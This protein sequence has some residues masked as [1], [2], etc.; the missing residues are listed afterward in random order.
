MKKLFLL[1]LL[2]FIQVYSQQ[3]SDVIVY[4]QNN[5]GFQHGFQDFAVDDNGQI[6]QVGTYSDALNPGGVTVFDG[7]HWKFTKQGENNFAFKTAYRVFYSSNSG[8]YYVYGGILRSDVAGQAYFIQKFNS[9]TNSWEIIGDSNSFNYF[10]G[11]IDFYVNETGETYATGSGG[12]W[13]LSPG[14][15]EKIFPENNPWFS[16]DYILPKPDG[17]MYLID[18]WTDGWGGS[19]IALWNYNG[20]ELDTIDTS[21]DSA[22]STKNVTLDEY[23]N[24]WMLDSYAVNT[25]VK[26]SGSSIR[27]YS[28]PAESNVSAR[29]MARDGDNLWFGM[30]T[31]GNILLKK[32]N[33][34]SENWETFDLGQAPCF[35]YSTSTIKI[36]VKGNYLYLNNQFY[37]VKYDK[38]QNQIAAIWSEYNTGL[39]N[40]ASGQDLTTIHID[41]FGHYWVNSLNRGA[42]MFNGE[43]WRTYSSCEINNY[44]I[45]VSWDLTTD[46]HGRVYTI[47]DSLRYLDNGVWHSVFPTSSEAQNFYGIAVTVD[48]S[49]H[50]W[51]ADSYNGLGKYNPDNGS[52]TFY[53]SGI[54]SLSVT[55]VMAASDGRIWLGYGVSANSSAS[56][57]DGNTFTNYFYDDGITLTSTTGICETPNGEIW[58]A[59]QNGIAK[60]ANETWTSYTIEDYNIPLTEIRAIVSDAN[61]T[62]W[63]GGMS[64]DNLKIYSFDGNQFTEH[65]ISEDA[66]SN[67]RD[68][69]Y[70]E[71]GNIWIVS[72][73]NVFVYNPS[74]NVIIGVNDEI[75]TEAE[76]FVLNQNYPNPFFKGSGGN[77]TTTI[78]YSIPIVSAKNFSLQRNVQLKIYDIL[79]REVAEL[80]NKKQAPGNYSVKF[81]ANNLPSG[82]YFYTLRSGDF[83]ATKKMILMK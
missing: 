57:F 1:I 7:T 83:I 63:I 53:N 72:G 25:L 35:P 21:I 49:N 20:T 4:S 43:R 30:N 54:A 24:I 56:V 38:T 73:S 6:I 79:G 65:L 77:P 58:F 71:N 42:A 46:G 37:I 11:V 45:A 41:K 2:M 44:L 29:T 14:L 50:V 28:I 26:Y 9:S 68:L 31:N 19:H 51:F 60:F 62:I 23:G 8:T 70:D 27:T 82:I 33:I 47:G 12:F 64:S 40:D 10:Q 74:G 78:E 75:N 39:P 22:Y 52:F 48:D 55:K 69:A 13:K 15:S 5:T 66:V 32:F 3:K 16:P 76:Q 59:F 36:V 80:V 61:G 81:D 67:V 18:D 34:V 17:S